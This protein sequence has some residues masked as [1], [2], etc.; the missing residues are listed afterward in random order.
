MDLS[1]KV[2]HLLQEE[3]C[4]NCWTVLWI[5]DLRSSVGELWVIVLHRHAC[6]DGVW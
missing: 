4:K 2:R 1:W 5:S 6:T 3:D